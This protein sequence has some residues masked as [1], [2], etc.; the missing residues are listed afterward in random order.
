M[1]RALGALVPAPGS[2][3]TAERWQVL[4]DLSA[5]DLTAGR[6]A[7]AHLD[8]LA[9]LEEGEVPDGDLLPLGVDAGSTWGVFAAEAPGARLTAAACQAHGPAGGDAE[10]TGWEL[11]GVKPWCSLAGRLSHA[12]VTAHV[13]GG[14]R[15]FAVPLRHPG[16]RVTDDPWVSRGLADVPSGP[17]VFDRVP[18]VPVGGTDWYLQRPGFAWGGIGVAACWFGGLLALARSLHRAA[19]RRPPDQIALLHLGA[20]DIAVHRCRCVL[21]DAA[22]RVDAGAADGTQGTALALRVRSV[23]ADAAEELLQRAG[24][25]LGPGPLTGDEDHARRVADLTVYVRQHHA[26]RDLAARGS[27]VA[28]SPV[29]PW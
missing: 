29:A 19:R 13:E 8:A 28:D 1:A 6:V 16:V 26:E 3:A 2:G 24:H 21:D 27:Q 9:I 12:L 23:V 15:L 25:A 14:R 4:A 22:R 20:A 5:A 11:A 18:A 10:H 7:E 17:V